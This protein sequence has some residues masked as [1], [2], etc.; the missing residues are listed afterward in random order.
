MKLKSIILTSIM[1]VTSV[2]CVS[3]TGRLEDRVII[4]DPGHG[5]NMNV[6]KGYD[7][8][9][10]MLDLAFKIKPLLEAEGATVHLTRSTSSDVALP[11]RTAIV[12]NVSLNLL[13]EKNIEIMTG[14]PALSS[15]LTAENAEIDKL[16]GSMNLIIGD[17]SKF[18]SLYLNYPWSSSHEITPTLQKIF[19][20]QSSEEITSRV[21][22]MSL[23]SNATGK[24]INE[25]RNGVITYYQGNE[26]RAKSASYFDKYTNMHLS[27][28]FATL[29]SNGIATLGHQNLGIAISD[30]HITRENNLPCVLVENGFHTNDFDRANLSNETFMQNLAKVYVEQIVEY[31]KIAPEIPVHVYRET[32]YGYNDLFADQWYADDVRL[33]IDNKFLNGKS[34]TEFGTYDTMSRAMLLHVL[35]KVDINFVNDRDYSS[36][37]M[38]YDFTDVNG[39]EWY[40]T[41]LKWADAKGIFTNFTL[42]DSNGNLN[43]NQA[44][45]REEVAQ[46]LLCYAQTVYE[47]VLYDEL[48]YNET[49][50]Y[51]NGVD[52]VNTIG[53]MSKDSNGNFNPKNTINKVE[54]AKII[55]RTIDYV[56]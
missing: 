41:A 1:L 40:Y 11:V 26:T 21:L 13:K 5:S 35:S 28:Q 48:S 25:T 54:I 52:F 44:V 50:T 39:S 30:F 29:M 37:A 55:N 31:F 24:P 18:A 16:I 38:Q 9:I 33:A 2:F 53:I 43:P 7:E 10:A 32:I 17:S 14:N 34:S 22:L 47:E 46:I 23:H 3:A 19:D 4:L 6:Y 51:K 20:Y 45:T 12:N 27:K 15:E 36:Y 8:G 56:K 42:H 49:I